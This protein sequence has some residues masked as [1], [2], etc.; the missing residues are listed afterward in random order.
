MTTSILNKPNSSYTPEV[1]LL[2]HNFESSF[3]F[4]E[5]LK[6]KQLLV[7]LGIFRDGIDAVDFLRNKIIHSGKPDPFIM[8]INFDCPYSKEVISEIINNTDFSKIPVLIFTELCDTDVKNTCNLPSNYVLLKPNEF[9]KSFEII[10][11]F[12]NSAIMH[13]SILCNPFSKKRSYLL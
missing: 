7:N 11:K 10:K 9:D 1:I 12:E 3:L 2:E 8:L 6:E 5:F 4:Q 13:Q